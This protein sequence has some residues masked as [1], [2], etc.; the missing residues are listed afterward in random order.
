MNRKLLPLGLALLLLAVLCACSQ[1]RSPQ[2]HGAVAATTGQYDEEKDFEVKIIDNGKAVAIVRYAGIKKEVRIPPAIQN[3]PVTVI[4]Y[5]AFAENQLTRVTI[6]NSVTIIR[7]W[8]FQRNELTQVAIPNSVTSIGEGAF[9]INQL[10]S[11]AIP[12]SV[13]S[14]GDHAFAGNQLTSVTIPSSVTSIG[15]A[16]FVNN[17]LTSVTIPDRVTAIREGAFAINH[18]TSIT[19]GA[20]V[21]LGTTS[22]AFNNFDP[23][24]EHNGSKGGTY[25]HKDGHWSIYDAEKDLQVK[26]TGTE[27]GFL[28]KIIDNGKAIRIIGYAGTN[29][30]LRIPPRIQNL[31][32]TEIGIHAFWRKNLT[33][34]TIPDSV[35]TIGGGAFAV[36]RLTSITIPNGV[37]SIG[38]R[39]FWENKITS[40]TIGANVKLGIEKQFP[41]VDHGFDDFYG[42]NNSKSGTYTYTGGRWDEIRTI[43]LN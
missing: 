3:L 1:E 4:G 23:F 35:T 7:D 5:E 37:T 27:E 31:P 21:T 33:G 42:K 38:D 40:I 13:T 14:I 18:L 19:I 15:K 22:P 20:N 29:E 32:V 30:A 11:V 2:Q 43:P 9:G 8:A 28:I 25:T 6:P 17:Q 24:Y 39:A 12:N 16:T 41:A 26:I 10:T 36:N 34:F